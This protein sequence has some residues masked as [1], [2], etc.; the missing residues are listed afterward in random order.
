MDT[1]KINM[2]DY[3]IILHENQLSIK[4]LTANVEKL[5][6]HLDKMVEKQTEMLLEHKE[7]EAYK[8]DIS[9]LGARVSKLENSL[10][11]VVRS[12]F[13]AI[14]TIGVGMILFTLKGG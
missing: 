13:G 10:S 2:Q 11:W 14:V 1:S 7:L 8:K 9:G 5:S 6:L 3:L 4:N 12:L